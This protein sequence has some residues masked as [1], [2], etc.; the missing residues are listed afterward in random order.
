M[1]GASRRASLLLASL[2]LSAGLW[3]QR[4]VRPRGEPRGRT[5][6]AEHAA[7]AEDVVRCVRGS[8]DVE[9]VSIPVAVW[10]QDSRRPTGGGG[11]W[12]PTEEYGYT[13][14]IGRIA[15]KLRV[16]W[17]SWLPS[18]TYSLAPA[19]V[20]PWRGAACASQ[21]RAGDALLF[22]HGFLGSPFDMAHACEALASDGFVVAAPELPESLAAS[23]EARE[24]VTREAI[25]AATQAALGDEPRRWG[26]WGHSA[27]S[28][29]ALSQPGE[30]ALGRACLACP[31]GRALEARVNDPL[32][33]CA[34][35]GDGCNR[36][37]ETSPADSLTLAAVNKAPPFST[38]ESA[39]LAYAGPSLP[40]RG[41]LLFRE[42]DALLPNHISFLWTR[43]NEAL[44]DLL[45]AFLP[46]A[47]AL[48]LFLLD[49]DTEKEARLAAPTAAKVVPALRR[50][51]GRNAVGG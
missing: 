4:P 33:L 13:V 9:G 51:F 49:F 39:D 42:G 7:E 10:C 44:F 36:F 31:L 3:A 19:G 37:S 34:S 6:R 22:A 1:S 38:F 12:V 20:P 47:K 11:A 28:G 46:L 30:F 35:E 29:T 27:G 18:R 26:I 8:V 24:G 23:Y 17:L 50:F 40:R 48:N 16:G 25:V 2:P 32:F 14:D 43:T 45:S 5:P 41:V 15:S 21:A